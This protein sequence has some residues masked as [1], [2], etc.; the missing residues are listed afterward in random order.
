MNSFFYRACLLFLSLFF[1]PILLVS[2]QGYEV[3]STVEDFSLP[4]VDGKSVSLSSFSD[5]KGVVVIFT[6]NTC[7]YAKGYEG[8]IIELDKAYAPKGFPVVAINPNDTKKQ[9]GDSM[10]KMKERSSLMGYSFPYLRDD[11]QKI[12][13]KF[14]ATKTPHMYV[15]SNK[16][17]AGFQVEYIGSLDDSPRDADD[18]KVT[19]VEDA[20]EA[21][22]KDQKPK[23]TSTKAIGCSIKWTGA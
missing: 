1:I 11:G 18:V 10:A 9:P 5:S 6:C 2:A 14:G 17:E 20:I 16:G 13:R 15:L 21:V 22:G 3:G 19:Y 23:I 12:A 8:R 4:N 7:P